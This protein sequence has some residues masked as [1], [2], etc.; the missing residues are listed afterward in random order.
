MSSKIHLHS[1]KIQ[2]T[3]KNMRLICVMYIHLKMFY[4]KN[5]IMFINPSK[6]IFT[7]I[8]AY[9]QYSLTLTNSKI[10][11]QIQEKII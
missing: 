6:Q 7:N 3:E 11:H 8:Y 1:S 5:K 10:M 9:K 4:L 2:E